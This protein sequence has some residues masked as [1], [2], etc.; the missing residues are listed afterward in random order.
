MSAV[1]K[2][3]ALNGRAAVCPQYTHSCVAWQTVWTNPVFGKP[4]F[5]L[6]LT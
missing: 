5:Q 2:C 6:M 1:A 3:S 4:V